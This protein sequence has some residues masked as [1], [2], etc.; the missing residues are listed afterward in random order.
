MQKKIYTLAVATFLS[1]TLSTAW[2][3]GGLHRDRAKDHNL[4]FHVEMT[5]G[6]IYPVVS[7]MVTGLFNYWLDRPVFETGY[8]YSFLS[9]KYEGSKLD[10]KNNSFNGITARE[11][12]NDIY[13]GVNVGYQTYKPQTFNFGFYASAGYKIDQ[14]RIRGWEEAD[15]GRHNIHRAQVGLTAF[16]TIGSLDNPL[17]VTVEAGCRY[18]I[19]VLY[20]SPYDDKA[21]SL[22]SGLTSHFAV[23]FA[24]EG[25]LQD[26]GVFANFNHYNLLDKEKCLGPVNELRRWTVGLSFSLTPTQISNKRSE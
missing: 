16:T 21:K 10:V 12:F 24:G 2:A 6:N 17:K 25:V 23:K 22:E 11:L 26:F 3:Q 4:Y 5:S 15:Y 1:A 13:V 9:A 18:N 20:N 8:N 14:F 7:S 19:P